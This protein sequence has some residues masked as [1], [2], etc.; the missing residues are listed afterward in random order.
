MK[1]GKI[2]VLGFSY[3]KNMTNSETF[4]RN[5]LSSINILFLKSDYVDEIL[6][7]DQIYYAV[8]NLNLIQMLAIAV[9]NEYRGS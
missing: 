1:N 3:S 7:G 6:F 8:A 4:H 5:I 2:Y 9:K